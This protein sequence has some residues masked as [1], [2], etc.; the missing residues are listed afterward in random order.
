M[1]LRECRRR[2]KSEQVVPVV[3][4]RGSLPHPALRCRPVHVRRRRCPGPQSL[5]GWPRG[6]RAR[7]DRHR[8]Q[9]EGY[10]EILGIDVTTAEDGA[11]WLTF[12]RSLTARGLSGVALVNSDAHAGPIAA[13]GATLPGA[14]WQRC[15]TYYAA[16]L[17]A[18]TPKS[19]WP[20]VKTLLHSAFDQPGATSFGAQYDQIIDA[21]V[22]KL[23]KVADHLEAA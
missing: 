1:I 7:A 12:P 16:N 5:R 3:N 6:Q 23:P 2:S 13:I 15:R 4:S 14:S 21:M 22:D 19:S 18:V 17:M 9:R 20:W 8:G 10:R 11:S